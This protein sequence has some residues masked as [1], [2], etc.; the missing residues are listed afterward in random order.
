ME[1]TVKPT[2]KEI[3]ELLLERTAAALMADDFDAFAKWFHVPH[4]VSTADETKVLET[5]DDARIMFNR[6]VHDYRRKRI[7]QLVRICEVAEYRS[8]TRIEATHIS[9]MM[10]GNERISDPVPVFSVLQFIDGSWKISSSQYAVDKN[11][12]VGHALST[13]WPDKSQS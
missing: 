11:T 5:L 1:K 13:P 9:H 2:A 12:T 6:V 3:S 7:T 8:E 10:A 4:F